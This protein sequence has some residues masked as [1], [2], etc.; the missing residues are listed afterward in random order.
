MM[1]NLSAL[2]VRS[3][4]EPGRYSD[5]NGLILVCKASGSKSWI[6]RIQYRGK[7]RDIGLG[8]VDDVSL[9]EARERAFELRK[10]VREGRDL[11]A[12]R[13]Q[14]ERAHD[15]SPT[16][17]SEAK[18]FFAERSPSWS[19]DKHRA[20]WTSTM[21]RYVYPDIGEIPIDEVRGPDVR[22]LLVPIWQTKAETA[23]RVL[24]RITSVL[25]YAHSKG[26]RE[27][28]APLRSIRAGLGKQT[29]KAEQLCRYAL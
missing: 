11:I 10:S 29:K 12:E 15:H 26:L 20:Q 18:A 2:K 14:A 25:D 16:F 24:Q 28:E 5:G 13:Q 27:H 6:L 1:G 4:S 23:R 7:R 22:A 21:E 17:Q 3:I 19:N 8:S 9:A